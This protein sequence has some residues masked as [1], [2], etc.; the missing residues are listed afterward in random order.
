MKLGRIASALAWASASSNSMKLA[1]YSSPLFTPI[2]R[3]E[4]K[5]ADFW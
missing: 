5:I 1:S 4:I 2:W 3:S